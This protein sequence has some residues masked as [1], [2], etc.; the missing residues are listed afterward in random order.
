MVV[1]R[2]QQHHQRHSILGNVRGELPSA[3]VAVRDPCI[4]P[5]PPWTG[6]TRHNVTGS[7]PSTQNS[8]PPPTRTGVCG[9]SSTVP[10]G[11]RSWWRRTN[12]AMA[13]GMIDTEIHPATMARKMAILTPVD[14]DVDG[15]FGSLDVAVGQEFH[16]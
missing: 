15:R 6:V 3:S 14:R 1:T 16:C 9:I 11:T 2:E 5:G 7:D 4:A 10:A 13:P 8:S 12:V